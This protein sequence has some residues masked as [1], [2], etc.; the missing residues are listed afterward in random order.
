MLVRKSVS[1]LSQCTVCLSRMAYYP[2]VI[3]PYVPG[4]NPQYTFPAART[5]LKSVHYTS[6]FEGVSSLSQS[7]VRLSERAYHPWVS[8]SERTYHPWV[9]SLYACPVVRTTLELVHYMPL[10]K[11]VWFLI[12]ST[13]RCPEGCNISDSVHYTAGREGVPSLR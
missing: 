7:T 11:R 13:I 9:S 8:L 6:A 10:L 4:V 12:Q 3:P 1:S 2:W 5:I